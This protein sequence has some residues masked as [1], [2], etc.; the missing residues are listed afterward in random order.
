MREATKK[1][2][3]DSFGHLADFLVHWKLEGEVTMANFYR[4]LNGVWF[5]GWDPTTGPSD[6]RTSQGANI[7]M[8]T[9]KEKGTGENGLQMA[10]HLQGIPVCF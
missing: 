1:I 2:P 7:Q 9:G 3:P 5:L 6:D 8:G 10:W 4:W